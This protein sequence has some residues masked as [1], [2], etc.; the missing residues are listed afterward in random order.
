[1]VKKQEIK[2][3]EE[4]RVRSVWDSEKEEWYFSVVDVVE[5]LT[6]SADPKQY[7][8][9]MRKRD[10]ELDARWGTICTL[11][12]LTANDGKKYRSSVATCEG[13][14]RIIQSI[15]SPKAEP[16]KQWMAAVAAERLNQMQDPE[17]SI[18]QAILDYKRLGYSDTWIKRRLKSIEIR[19]DLTDEWKRSGIQEGQQYATLTDILTRAWSGRTTKEYKRLKGLRKENLRDNMTNLELLFNSLAE[20]S[21]T[22][23]SKNESPKGMTETARVARRGGSIA[24]T[25]RTQLEQ[26]LGHT[27]ITSTKASD[28][29]LPTDEDTSEHKD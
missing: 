16:F 5:V 29:L 18:D 26:Q 3:F 27:I 17:R 6:D 4:K 14:F 12:Q 8:K 13:L 1:M 28:Y 23:I 7:I 21:A 19:K 20:A 9:K 22:E 15:S 25:A 2:L 11:T 24:K 10:P